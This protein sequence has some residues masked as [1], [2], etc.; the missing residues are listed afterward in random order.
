MRLWFAN[1]MN[2]G[3]CGVISGIVALDAESE[4]AKDWRP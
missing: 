4:A 2:L 1:P 3:I